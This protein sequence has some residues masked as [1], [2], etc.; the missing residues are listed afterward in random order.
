MKRSDRLKSL[1]GCNIRELKTLVQ[2]DNRLS[3]AKITTDLNIS[4]FKPMSQRTVRRY[5]KKLDYEYAVNIKNQWLST[6][7]RKA[8][9][10]IPTLDFP[11]LVKENF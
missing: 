6:K 5:L 7:H 10:T 2:D 4:L 8:R 9:G 1:S 3:T 11:R